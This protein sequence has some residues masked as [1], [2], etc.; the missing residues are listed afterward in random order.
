MGQAE[1]SVLVDGVTFL[2]IAAV[3]RWRRIGWSISMCGQVVK[4]MYGLTFDLPGF[5]WFS[6][7]IFVVYAFHQYDHRDEPW[8]SVK[9]RS[10]DRHTCGGREREHEHA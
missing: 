4:M 9:R 5:A 1:W 6:V 2:G 8:T 10:D 7:L 3:G